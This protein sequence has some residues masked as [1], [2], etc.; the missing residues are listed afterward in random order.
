MADAHA[1]R[2]PI[3]QRKFLLNLPNFEVVEQA[4]KDA[5]LLLF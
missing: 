3:R 5:Q 4:D 1:E 2:I